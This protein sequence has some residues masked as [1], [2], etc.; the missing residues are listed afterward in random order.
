MKISPIKSTLLTAVVT[1]MVT[2]ITLPAHAQEVAWKLANDWAVSE[3]KHNGEKA[4][5]ASETKLKGN[6]GGGKVEIQDV[7][8][9]IP[10]KQAPDIKP[11]KK[12][13]ASM[14]MDG[15]EAEF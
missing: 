6:G 7:N 14:K 2:A 4:E 12:G 1:L 11:M 5:E 9:H 8:L 15:V 13:Q 10:S 3:M